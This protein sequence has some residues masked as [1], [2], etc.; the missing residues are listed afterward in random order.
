MDFIVELPPSDGHDT[1]FVCVDRLT[2]MAHFIP[3]TSDVTAEQAAQL[4][5]R[6]VWKLHGLRSWPPVCL[7][8]HSTLAQTARYRGQPVHGVPPT[9]RWANRTS[10]SD[11]RTIFEDILRLS[12]GRLVSASPPC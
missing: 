1:I 2:K 12:I 3:T 8:L 6:H 10:K 7:S 11:V 9:I 5:Y 4:Y